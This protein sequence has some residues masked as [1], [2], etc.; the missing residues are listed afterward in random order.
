M[1]SMFL[2]ALAGVTSEVGAETAI[3]KYCEPLIS[4]ASASQLEAKLLAEGFSREVLAGQQ[5]LKQGEL[6][7]GLSEAPRVCFVQAPLSMSLSQGFAAA[8]R[9]AGRLPGAVR[10]PSTKGPDGAPVRVWSAPSKNIALVASQ[11]TAASGQKVMTFILMP[12][13]KS[14]AR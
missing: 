10:S 7:L 12:L 1:L 4:G 5:V 14:A 3:Q 11:Q 6:I 8:D 9:W 2:L 13:P